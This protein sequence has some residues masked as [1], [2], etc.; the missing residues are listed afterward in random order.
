MSVEDIQS[1]LKAWE[2]DRYRFCF[3]HILLDIRNSPEFQKFPDTICEDLNN[4][5]ACK[6]ANSLWRYRNFLV[7]E[8]LKED[9]YPSYYNA[10]W[11]LKEIALKYPAATIGDA[12]YKAIIYEWLRISLNP[13]NDRTNDFYFEIEKLNREEEVKKVIFKDHEQGVLN[14]LFITDMHWRIRTRKYINWF[15][16]RYDLVTAHKIIVQLSEPGLINKSA[17]KIS[18]I[19]FKSKSFTLGLFFI[20]L[21]LLSVI[22]ISPLI[23]IP[24]LVTD[25]SE[26]FPVF[27]Q[28]LSIEKDQSDLILY[29]NPLSFLVL[30]IYGFA[31][32]IGIAFLFGWIDLFWTKL[33]LP[34]LLGAIG[35]G[36]IPLIITAEVWEF[37]SKIHWEHA[38]LIFILAALGSAIYLYIEISNLNPRPEPKLIRSRSWSILFIGMIESLLISLVLF[39]LTSAYFAKYRFN[40]DAPKVLC[41]IFGLLPVKEMLLFASLALLIGIFIQILWEEKPITQPL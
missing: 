9:F 31:L 29:N 5:N 6:I 28:G 3:D 13:D 20:L 26:Y 33:C 36:F 14:D 22:I 32:F 1:F 23:R 4:N 11:H 15:L 41:G 2:E 16:S 12:L 8:G 10:M 37:A 35:V 18:A 40:A 21:T 38:A 27:L 30:G 25:L 7:R 24:S 19:L 39:D 34:R 17:S